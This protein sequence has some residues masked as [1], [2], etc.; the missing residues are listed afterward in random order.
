MLRVETDLLLQLP[1]RCLQRQLVR[2]HDPSGHLQEH[3]THGIAILL[4]E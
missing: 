3:L 2:L 4:D 1:P